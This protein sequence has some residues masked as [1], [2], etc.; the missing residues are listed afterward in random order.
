MQSVVNVKNA[1]KD[2]FNQK[3]DKYPVRVVN[4][5]NIIHRQDGVVNAYSVRWGGKVKEQT[6][7]GWL[8]RMLTALNVWL[9]TNVSKKVESGLVPTTKSKPL[10]VPLVQVRA[11][12]NRGQDM[13]KS[14]F[15][16]N[17]KHVKRAFI[18][19]GEKARVQY[20]LREGVLQKMVHLRVF[21][22]QKDGQLTVPRPPAKNV[23]RDISIIIVG[24]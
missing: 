19:V 23:K 4:M 15:T 22:A 20:V 11:H 3:E 13:K 8:K 24:H 9:V 14:P 17:V 21:P 12:L 18:L 5:E 10:N 2:M 1:H 6:M 7:G 16:E